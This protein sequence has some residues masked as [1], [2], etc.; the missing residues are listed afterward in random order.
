MSEYTAIKAVSIS[1]KELLEEHITNRTEPELNAVIIDLRS[2]KEMRED[3]QTVGISL[4]LYRVTRNGHTLNHPPR[5][6]ATN[7]VLPHPIPVDLYYLVTPIA[8]DSAD[9]QTLMGRVMQ[10]FNDHNTIRGS[11][12]KDALE[13]GTE[14]LRLT[15][16][17]LSLEELARVWDALKEPYQL[18][19]SYMV[20]LVTI[21]SD[22][23]P[24]QV[25]PVAVKEAKY[26]E[27]LD[28]S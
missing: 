2:P 18:S 19:V 23:E 25:S 9:E 4:W 16:D 21:D 8:A 15:L 13:G 27:I 22:H 17:T 24:I 12:L 3:N 20:Q 5:R 10:V 6:V 11:D 14:E 26:T 7:Q 28:S 1:L